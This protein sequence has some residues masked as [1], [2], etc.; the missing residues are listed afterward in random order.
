MQTRV[1]KSGNSL[2]IRLPRELS[3]PEGTEVEIVRDGERLVVSPARPG[4]LQELAGFLR[5]H[6][7]PLLVEALDKRPEW[8]SHRGPYSPKAPENP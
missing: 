5:D 7:S 3:F 4:S 6:P 2:A 1:F 8:P